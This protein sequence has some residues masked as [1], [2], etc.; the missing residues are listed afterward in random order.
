MK[1]YQD[2]RD[3]RQVSLANGLRSRLPGSNRV[4]GKCRSLWCV[5]AVLGLSVGSAVMAPESGGALSPSDSSPVDV[6]LATPEAPSTWT[7]EPTVNQKTQL[8][9]LISTSCWSDTG[10]VAVGWFRKARGA[11][12]SP[13]AMG[14]D[15][16]TWTVQNF[17]VPGLGSLSSVSCVSS[18][19]CV[20]VGSSD[21]GP[22]IEKWNGVRW[23]TKTPSITP[24]SGSLTTVSCVSSTFCTALGG[25]FDSSTYQW[26]TLSEMWN[27]QGWSSVPVL[28]P[29]Y[30]S[31]TLTSVDCLSPSWCQA[32][33]E[34]YDGNVAYLWNGSEWTTEATAENDQSSGSGLGAVTCSSE[35]LCFAVGSQ[36]SLADGSSHPLIEDW[37]GTNWT[38]QTVA[39]P[40]NLGTAG[41]TELNGVSCLSSDECVAVGMV[42]PN[43]GNLTDYG[44]S[45]VWDGTSWS[46]N[47]PPM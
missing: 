25:F 47:P 22:L 23:M 41:M 33:G 45:E 9:T 17:A 14:W 36:G 21:S 29:E 37:N 7:S 19:M 46:K 34:T 31:T 20:A 15:G 30:Y 18:S 2:L 6:S 32:V 8:G 24:S 16:T 11:G 10:C 38:L 42:V 28:A 5:V 12:E 27:G 1:N 40:T 3:T 26:S 4:S 43:N 39:D 44:L 35:S 13:L